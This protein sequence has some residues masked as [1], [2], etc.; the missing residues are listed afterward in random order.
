MPVIDVRKSRIVT[1]IVY[2]GAGLSGKT[3]NLQYIHDHIDPQARGRLVSL[4]VKTE[5]EQQI[6]LLPV[7]AGK[8]KGFDVIHNLCTVPGQSLYNK[9]RKLVLKG[10]DGVVF[11]ADSSKNRLMANM[12]ALQNLGDNLKEYDVALKDMVHVIQYNKRD[13]PDALP[14]AE[15]RAKLN[16]YGVLEF[17]ASVKTGV[18]VIETLKAILNMVREDT[19]KRL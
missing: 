13:L 1:K 6:D 14:V 15:L 10:T 2:Y 12:D 4:S 8:V 7:R 5:G 11:V 16:P 18:G 17:E 9:T 3:A 19:E